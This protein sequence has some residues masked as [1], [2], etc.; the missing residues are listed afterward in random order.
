MDFASEINEAISL[1]LDG[2]KLFIQHKISENKD[3]LKQFFWLPQDGT[4][5]TVLNYLIAAHQEQEGELEA[6]EC[7]SDLTEFIDY[8]LE[9]SEDKNVGEPLHQA[10]VAGK[11]QLAFHLLG[12]ERCIEENSR[13]N[14]IALS[15]EMRK[16][17]KANKYDMDRRD[18]EGRT[19]I[20]L[21]LNIK[22]IALLINILMNKLNIHATTSMT[23]ARVRFQPIHQ[24]VVL[25]FADGVR[26][27][28]AEGA[29]LANPLG[30]MKDTPLILAARL[31]KINAMEA[32]LEFPGENLQLEAENNNL[33]EDKMTGHTA[34]EELCERIAN[35]NE[36]NE[37]IRGV[38]M[39]LCRGAEPPLREEMRQLLSSNRIALLKAIDKYLEDKPG[40]VDAF[41]NRCHVTDG[42]LHNIVYAD[43][44]WGSSIRHLFGT[45]SE[46]AFIVENLVIRKYNDSQVEQANGTP[47]SF[48]TAESLARERNHL[49]LYAEFV[50][51]YTQA[52]DSQI[53]T[54]RWSTMR[55][56]IAEGR[57]DWA[58]VVNYARNHPTSRTRIIW[59]EM[60]HP[61][62][63]LHEDI[64]ETSE[65]SSEHTVRM[66]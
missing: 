37:A 51:R 28:A 61:M 44:S 21:I 45:P 41:V 9:L 29:Q 43:H 38:A 59:G 5:M 27:L 4:Q 17:A 16:K 36:K 20:S 3:Y 32:L 57:C 10:I 6:E 49:K 42:P 12:I 25:D 14:V 13:A 7:E 11:L 66:A 53:F 1:G 19:L 64:E 63:K 47:L 15:E 46:A 60:F 33:F 55:W 48:A 35:N 58:T 31:G 23:D 40:L 22:N 34:M 50:R 65:N 30:V 56:M 2:F 52:Y 24:A 18:S 54:N 62:P 39:L 26:L 8:V